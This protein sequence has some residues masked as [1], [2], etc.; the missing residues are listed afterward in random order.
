MTRLHAAMLIAALTLS[1]CNRNTAPG[2]DREARIDPAPAPAEVVG[3]ASA[4][5]NVDTAIVKP[6]T[7]SDADIAA[8]GG[9]G[10]Q[11]AVRLTSVAYPSFLFRPGKGG[12]IKLNGKLIPLAAK[13]RLTFEADG[14]TVVLR[15]NGEESQT[16]LEGIDMI[17]VPPGAQDELG[18]S[19]FVDCNGNKP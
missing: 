10:D 15:S 2:N 4:L 12:A 5:A 9:P 18:Y 3:A 13:S 1:A 8:L 11:C 6:E 7:M 16:G 17:V 19:G 14:L